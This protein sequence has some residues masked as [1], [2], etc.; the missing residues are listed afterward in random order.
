M[1]G[2]RPAYCP[3]TF[4]FPRE[5]RPREAVTGLEASHRFWTRHHTPRGLSVLTHLSIWLRRLRGL[6][7][8]P[9]AA[10]WNISRYGEPRP[11]R[12]AARR[13]RKSPRSGRGPRSGRKSPRECAYDRRGRL[14]RSTERSGEGGQGEAAGRTSTLPRML[15]TRDD[16]GREAGGTALKCREDSFRY[17]AGTEGPDS[18]GSKSVDRIS[19]FISIAFLRKQ[20]MPRFRPAFRL[21]KMPGGILGPFCTLVQTL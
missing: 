4:L 15:P 5:P 7:T 10:G 8:W 19:L 9:K 17:R 3:L 6:R 12:T 16:D 11:L 2:L 1:P 13:G 21:R 20:K 18:A 14:M